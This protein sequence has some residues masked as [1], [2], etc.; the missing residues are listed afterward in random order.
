MASNPPFKRSPARPP[1]SKPSA[2]KHR[3][4][5]RFGQHWLKSDQILSQIVSAGELSADDCVLE[6]GPGQGALTERLLTTA[7]KVLA[8]EIDRDLCLALRDQFIAFMASGQ[9]RLVESDF[10]QINFEQALIDLEL[11][12]P[13]KAIANIPYY[14]TAPILE[15]LLGTIR[16]PNPHPFDSIVLLVQKEISDRLCATPGTKA[17]GALTIRA[18]YLA[19]C[20]EICP[21]PPS[22]FK[23]PPKVESAVIRLRPRPFPTP[24]K[25]PARLTQIIKLGFSQKRK[26]L[27]NNLQSIIERDALTTVLENLS[28]NPQTRAEGLGVPQWVA[29]SD[30]LGDAL[31]P[32]RN[33]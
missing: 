31:G 26:M 23:P 9:F 12:R 27:R 1:A 25:D 4:R 6:I 5:K 15:K 30:A 24:A 28:I 16:S 17:N 7:A 22:A 20:E 2:S 18:Q 10:L 32:I 19:D 29:L 11:D 13:N 8:V 21:V 33:D 14:I 3:A